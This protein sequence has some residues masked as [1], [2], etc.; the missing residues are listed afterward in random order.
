M[1]ELEVDESNKS[2]IENEETSFMKTD[3]SE[4]N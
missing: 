1:L 2:D 3:Q 4:A